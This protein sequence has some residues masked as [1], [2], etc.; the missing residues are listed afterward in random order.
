MLNAADRRSRLELREEIIASSTLYV[1]RKDG[2]MDG[3]RDIEQKVSKGK[4]TERIWK[5]EQK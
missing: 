5:G 3:L 1:D 4:Q 2:A